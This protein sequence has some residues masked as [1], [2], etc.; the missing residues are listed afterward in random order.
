ME[1]FKNF[2]NG[3][4]F[5]IVLFL[6]IL[7]IGIS[8]YV[9]IELGDVPAGVIDPTATPTVTPTVKPTNRPTATPTVTPT[10]SPTTTPTVT[11]TVVPSVKPS[12]VPTVNENIKLSWPIEDYTVVFEYSGDELFYNATLDDW[13]THTGID[14]A[15]KEGSSVLACADGIVSD[16]YVDDKMGT[17]VKI[18]HDGG[19]ETVYQSLDA[20]VNVEKGQEVKG[21]DVLGTVS[22]SAIIE[23]TTGPHLHFECYKNGVRENPSVILQNTKP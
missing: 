14:I 11:P 9:M 21:G 15:A 20:Y 18:T 7:A 12:D 22:T 8:G 10:T 19:L 2:I 16:V 1:K 17:T 5:Y 23:C 13:R 4:G 6:C 3:K